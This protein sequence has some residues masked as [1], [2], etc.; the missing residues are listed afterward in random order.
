MIT[1]LGSLDPQHLGLIAGISAMQYKGSQKSTVIGACSSIS[2]QVPCPT[3][4]FY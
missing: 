4:R 3:S 1:Q 2:F